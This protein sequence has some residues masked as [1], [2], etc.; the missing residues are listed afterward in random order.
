MTDGFRRPDNLH[1]GRFCSSAV[2]QDFN[3]EAA[4]SW[5]IARP[6]SSSVIAVCNSEAIAAFVEQ[7]AWQVREDAGTGYS[8]HSRD[9]GLVK[10]V[11]N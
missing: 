11:L 6:E 7:E 8:I 3:Q 2:P 1:R 10:P 5:L 9:F 4:F